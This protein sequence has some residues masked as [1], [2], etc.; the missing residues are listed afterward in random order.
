[1]SLLNEP[2]IRRKLSDEVFARLKLLITAGELAP[3]D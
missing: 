2:I 1:M 3:G